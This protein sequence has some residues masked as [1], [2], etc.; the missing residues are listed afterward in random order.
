MFGF[1]DEAALYDNT[2]QPYGGIFMMKADGSDKR[3]LTEC[4]GKLPLRELELVLSGIDT[5]LGR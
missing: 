5:V 1:K 3:Q 2:F 4:V